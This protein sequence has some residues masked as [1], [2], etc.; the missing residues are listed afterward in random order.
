MNPVM[1][2]GWEMNGTGIRYSARSSENVSWDSV[3]GEPG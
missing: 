2:P 3:T 1:L